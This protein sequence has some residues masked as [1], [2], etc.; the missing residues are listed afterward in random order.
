ME[1]GIVRPVDIENEMKGAYLDYAMSVITARALPDVRDGLKPVQRRILYA[2][3]DMGLRYDRPHKKSARIVGEVLGKYHPHG[4]SAVYDAMVRLAQDFSMRYLLVDGQGNFGSVDGDPPAAMRYTEAR[5]A[6]I[7]EEMVADIGKNTVD[8]YPNFDETLKQPSVLP[9]NLPNLLLNGTAGI[10]VGMATNIPPHN[11]NEIADAC[12]YLIDNWERLEDVNV[13]DLMKFVHGPDFPTGATILGIEGIRNAYATGRGRVVMRAKAHIEDIKGNRQRIVITELPYQV[14]KATLIERIAELVRNRKIDT[15]SDLRDESDRRGMSVVIELKRGANPKTTL[16]QLLKHTQ[17]QGTFGV[18]MLALVNGEPK[19]LPLKRALELWIEHRREVI[20][21]RTEYDLERARARAHILE[22]LRIALEYLDEVI[23][24]I[25]KSQT[26]DTARQ[27]LV[28]RFKLTDIQATAILDMQLGRLAALE[29][30]KIEDEYKEVIQLI[31]YLEDLLRSPR[32]VLQLIRADLKGL[33]ERYGDARRTRILAEEGEN[34][35]DEDLIPDQ[36]VLVSLTQRGYIKRVLA[37]AYRTQRRGGRGITGMVTREE[38]V[39]QDMRVANTHDNILFFTDRGR[40]FQIKTHLL[41]EADRTAKGMPLV[42]FIGLDKGEAVTAMLPVPNENGAHYLVMA[43][44]KGKIKR[45]QLSEFEAVRPSGIIALTLEDG[46]AL[47]WV[48]LTDG[49]QDILIISANGQ[50]LRF[51]EDEVRPMGRTAAGVNAMRIDSKDEIA[52]MAIARPHTELLIVT[53][54]GFAKRTPIAEY[55][56]KGRATGGVR[57]LDVN[58][59]AE[60][61]PIVASLIVNPDAEIAIISRDGVVMRTEIKGVKQ[62]GRPTR[63]SK[64]MNLKKGDVVASVTIL[65][66]RLPDERAEA[67]TAGAT[68]DD[69]P[70]TTAKPTAKPT[71]R[72][73]SRKAAPDADAVLAKPSAT[74]QTKSIADPKK[75]KQAEQQALDIL[76]ETKDEGPRT[77]GSTAR[78][79]TDEGPPTTAKT[80]ARATTDD[81]PPTTAKTTAR[82]TTDDGPPTTAKTT[83]KTTAPKATTGKSVN[84]V[85]LGSAPKTPPSEPPPPARPPR[86]K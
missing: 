19:V 3:F 28:K 50:A 56:A 62:A 61:G 12:I 64:V 59:L 33:K 76:R 29:R 34:F 14:N 35:S 5:L 7:A 48:R 69:G 16:N 43:T 25:R 85:K 26:R 1:I 45:T 71:A 38:D 65:T 57:T 66:P 6:R 77:K 22:G 8:F 79:T 67:T 41:P 52:G 31:S 2:M 82:A 18:N 21:R 84:A 11:L 73:T 23:A 81:G 24:I 46:D 17:L 55:P 72:A 39:V 74:Q 15:I 80:T 30:K 20:R 68:T 42:N 58:K 75:A 9:A 86:K 70:P 32:K 40:V 49:T 51:S 4:D 44:R 27:N 10:A 63:G 47:G 60:T 13:D 78:A 36:D 54:D 53:R 83:A 37:D